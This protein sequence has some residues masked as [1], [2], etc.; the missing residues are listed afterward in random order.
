ME[1][2][3]MSSYYR[4]SQGVDCLE[5]PPFPGVPF[6]DEDAEA[7]KTLCLSA[8]PGPLI[9]TEVVDGDGAIVATLPDG[10][11]IVGLAVPIERTHDVLAIE[12][13][14]KLICQARD[15]LLQLLHCREQWK[16]QEELLKAQIRVLNYPL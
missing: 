9:V 1:D 4:D 7:L 5:L 10:S 6:E 11:H 8:T 13:N 14:G 16:R 12:A 2:V 3:S 15:L